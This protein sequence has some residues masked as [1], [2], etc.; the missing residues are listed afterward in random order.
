MDIMPPITV[1]LISVP[2]ALLLSLFG[3]QLVGIRPKICH[4]LFAAF[5][6]AFSSYLI[7]ALPIYFGYHTPILLIIYAVILWLVLRLPY[8]VS[9]IAVLLGL[10]SYGALESVLA[11]VVVNAIGETI[12]TILSQP[13][14][15]IKAFLPQA[16]VFLLITLIIRRKNISLFKVERYMQSKVDDDEHQ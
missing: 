12:E 8:I 9:Q 15:R 7:R 16:I 1:L 14:L 10:T 5:L 13:V 2:E 4:L 11:P 6:Q 3:L